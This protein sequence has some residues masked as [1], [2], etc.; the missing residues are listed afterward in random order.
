V[1]YVG[2]GVWDFQ[3][4]QRLGW[5]FI[6]IGSGTAAHRLLHAGAAAVLPNFSPS[7]EF[8]GAIS[9]AAIRRQPS[10]V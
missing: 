5:N 3:A 6:G 10:G 7:E 9:K 4:A 1:T 8:F 2:D